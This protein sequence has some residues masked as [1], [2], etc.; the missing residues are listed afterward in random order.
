MARDE[1]ICK[2]IFAESSAWQ[3]ICRWQMAEAERGTGEEEFDDTLLATASTASSPISSSGN[4][5]EL[6]IS[7]KLNSFMEVMSFANLISD[8]SEQINHHPKII[9]DYNT[10]EL[11]LTTHSIGGIS[12]LDFQLANFIHDTYNE[13]FIKD[14]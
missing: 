12:N 13:L 1:L 3:Q 9:I 2:C 5:N 6:K 14:S 8:K 4:N 7:Y 10:I 11:N